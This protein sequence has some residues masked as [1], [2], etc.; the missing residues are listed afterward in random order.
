[1]HLV[2]V[3]LGQ[4]KD[5]TAVSI[6]ERMETIKPVANAPDQL[7]TDPDKIIGMYRL[8]H[9]EQAPRETPYPEV[10]RRIKAIMQLPALLDRAK[11]IIDYTGVGRPVYDMMVEQGLRPATISITN[12]EQIAEK[13]TGYNVPKQDIVAVIEVLL[14]TKRFTYTNKLR[15]ASRFEEQMREYRVKITRNGRASFEALTEDIHDDLVIAVALPLWYAE[16][17]MGGMRDVRTKNEE[18][19]AVYNPHD[20]LSRRGK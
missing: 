4:A 16:R 3:D 5:F 8:M 13:S 7:Y 2:G 1:M 14:E 10:V 18:K 9:L 15:I 17:T 6:I 11:L 20:Y 12:G 19:K